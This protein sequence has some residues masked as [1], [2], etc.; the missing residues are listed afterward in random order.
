MET[1]KPFKISKHDVMRAWQRV[2]AN[3]GTY[4]VDG[5][6]IKQ[7]ESNL[8]SNLYKIWNRMSS[9]S[10]FPPPV[11]TVAIPKKTG[12]ERKLGIPTVSDRIAQMVVKLHFEPLVEP[13]FHQD[14]YGYRSNRSAHQAL[15]IT[16]RR[17]WRYNW[18]LEFDIKGLFDNINHELL[19]KAVRKHTDKRWIILYIER[20]LTAPIQNENGIIVT[21]E[22]GVPQG[23]V[24]SPVLSNLFMHYAFDK[25]MERN[26]P[27]T[28]FCRYAD[29]ALAHCQHKEEAETLKHALETRLR[30][31]GLEMHPE[32]TKIVYCKDDGR[33]EE[34]PVIS[35]DFLG[36]TFRPRR[37][38]NRWGKY[39]IGFTPAMSAK[40][41]KA[42]RQKVRGWKLHLRS[43]KDLTDLAQ[44]FKA[45]IQGW[46][47][48]YGRFCKSAMFPTF[49]HLNRKL[50]LWATKK[51][52]R[53]KRH[54]RRA[55][56]RLGE[57]AKRSPNLFPHWRFGVR[58]M[59]G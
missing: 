24:I 53:L 22:R 41:G 57:I 52:K 47:N 44:M 8:K 20:W 42:I 49:R 36:Y 55:E 3:K 30:E 34:H 14:S 28:P 11:K 46:I 51:F 38:K 18:V 37:S 10:Y 21:R 13:W 23:G 1:T 19:M 40:A 48:Y 31:C 15:E 16:R 54:R 58:P 33:R 12:G 39:F 29:D 25:W 50:C 17:C 26:F 59:V 35:F 27:V 2:K 5:E 9:G 6:T 43:D 4:G 45:Q 7:F 32:K 56:H